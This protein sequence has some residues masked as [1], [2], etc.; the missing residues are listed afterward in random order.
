MKILLTSCLVLL[1]SLAPVR[2]A[3]SSSD[4]DLVAALQDSDPDIR[5]LAA[6]LLADEPAP[7][8]R[9]ALLARLTDPGEAWR[10]RAA[11]AES[12]ARLGGQDERAVAA[13]LEVALGADE[14]WRVRAAAVEASLALDGGR[15]L[16]RALR[17]RQ[18]P[19]RVGNGRTAVSLREPLADPQVLDALQDPDPRMRS[20]ARTALELPVALELP[21]P[22]PGG[23]A[24]LL[25]EPPCPI[26]RLRR[27]LAPAAGTAG[28]LTIY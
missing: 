21:E 23:T 5:A 20:L 17:E 6:G 28:Q 14:D 8:A 12:L 1:A 13:V 16:T 27:L 24:A 18:E 25:G 19:A 11:A 4:P 7:G 10:V 26:E 3:G 9:E 15:R 22:A 2:A